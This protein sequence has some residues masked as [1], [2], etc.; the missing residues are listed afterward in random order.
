MISDWW[1]EGEEFRFLLGSTSGKIFG[2]TG[3]GFLAERRRTVVGGID[4]EE[5]EGWLFFNDG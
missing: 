4:I 5:L 3:F 2:G 1:L